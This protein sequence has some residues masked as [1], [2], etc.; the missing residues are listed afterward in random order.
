MSSAAKVGAFMLV[1]LGILGYF[2]LK[3]EDIR[4]DRGAGTKKVSA[5]FDSVAG[6]DKKSAVRVAGVRVG[7]VSDIRLRPDGK[8]EV[9]MELDRDVQL[10]QN[11]NAKVANLGLLG[12]KYVEL[13]PGSPNL[14]VIPEGQTVVLRGS[15]PAS[16]DDVTNQ[17]SAIAT[18]VKA[19][20]ESLRGVVGGPEGQQRLADIVGNVHEIT[21]QM[22]A[23]IV[24]NR[25]NVDATFA[26]ARDITAQLKN[27]IPRLAESIDRVANQ[28]NG[29]IG[30][31]RPELHQVIGNLR[32]LSK[33]LR[34]TTDNLNSI[35]GQIKSGEGTVG[36]LV[37]SNETH[38]KLTAALESVESGVNELKQT[39]GRANRIG[40]DL[41]MKSDY[42]AGLNEAKDESRQLDSGS[43]RSAV[44]LRLIP[45]PERNRFYNLEL[46]DDP[47]GRRRD[48]VIET[49]VTDP[50]TGA[51]NTTVTKE[52]KFDRAFLVSAQAGWTLNPMSVRLGLFDS[53]GGAGIDYHFNPRITITGEAFDFGKRRDPNPH[54]RLYG[55]YV[56][57]KEKPRTP[58]VF[59][60]S[61]VDNVFNDTAF[62][63]G[64]GIRWRDDDLKYLLSSIPVGK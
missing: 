49:T 43:G 28:L 39:L 38:D 50:A 60:S 58:L 53:T 16:I 30:E 46:V 34:T 56:V 12:E 64:G 62:I 17:V 32:D 18:D 57:R 25:S 35:T 10:H 11:A 5:I 47:H 20:T 48:K 54:L 45:N 4:V 6:L 59:V 7:K 29:T 9:T 41:G 2:V 36:K 26:N 40:L 63:F 42:Y 14:P 27:D 33:D 15:Q 3:I 24:A 8:A 1:I 31:N 19:I 44:T 51:S 52:T 61:G 13:E 37:Y 55:E 22:R 21:V 23:L